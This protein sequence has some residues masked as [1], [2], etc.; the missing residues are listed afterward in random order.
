MKPVL[1]DLRSAGISAPRVDDDAWTGDADSVS[2]TLGSGDGGGT[3]VHVSRS[4]P[5]PDRVV[6][7]AEQV[8]E[9]ATEELW[10]RSVS[11]N[12]PACPHHPDR[13]PMQPTIQAGE[14]VWACPVDRT[15]FSPV[16]AL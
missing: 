6:A 2:A 13:H 12:W 3:G 11:T 10:G 16:G 4:A 14:A 7:M 8:Q 5:A 1:R 9:W 15:S